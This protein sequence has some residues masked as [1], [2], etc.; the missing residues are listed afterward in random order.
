[1]TSNLTDLEI[2]EARMK[3]WYMG[4]LEWKL[5][6]TQKRM[7]DFWR[8]TT[9]KTSILNISRRVGKSYFLT[10]LAV[11]QC[12]QKPKSIVK[13][14]QPEQKMIRINIRPIMDR[15][16]ADCPSDLRP[17]FKTQDN[18]YR[19]PNGSEIQLAGTDNG[20][21]E[22]LR[23]GDADLCL[24]DEAG[25]VKSELQY[26]VRSVL[27]PTTMLTRGK[28]ILSS[29]SPKEPDHDFAKYMED[30]ERTKT[31]LRVTIYDALTDNIGNPY[32]RITPEIVE[33]IVEEYPGGMASDDFRRECL[34]QIITDGDNA[35]LPEFNN[36]VA[37]DTVI[38]WP[39]P[40]FCDRYVSMDIGFRDLTVVLFGYY[41]FQNA[42]LVI[43]DEI[44]MN[45]PRMTTPKLCEDIVLK[46]KEL[47]TDPLTQEFQKPYL[48]VCDNNLIVIN[49]LQRLHGLTFL[50]TAKDN[51]EAAVNNTRLMIEQR[52]IYIHP[53]CET[54]IHHMK[55]A[56]WDKKRKEFARS[57]DDGHYDAVD[58]LIYM[59]RNVDKR[60]NPFPKDY[61]FRHLSRGDDLFINPNY[62]EDN[63]AYEK[64]KD[65][66]IPKKKPVNKYK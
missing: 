35:V 45:G 31:I 17:E 29:T 30:A 20:N 39:R 5:D 66:F 51:K 58:A 10:V 23:G 37:Q 12:I 50:P 36:E 6:P 40:P 59:V 15:I 24:V 64:F 14:L 4:N 18:I 2:K 62:R 16:L 32:P 38:D 26:I 11:Q 44:V 41:D 63:G 47:W 3:L 25:F 42:V 21:H 43:E 1:M 56:V 22:K 7:Y 46:E 57:P 55:H 27:L 60:K 61:R 8:G 65:M 13:F 33:E 19:F 49:D 54:L 52:Q 28:I 9:K 34:C 53:R 48:R